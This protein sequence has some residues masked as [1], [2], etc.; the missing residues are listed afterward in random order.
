MPL[1]IDYVEFTS[2]R[3]EATQAFFDA[4]FGWSFVDYGS[5]YRDIQQAGL[6]AGLER[7]DLAPPLVVL[8]STDLEA[9]RDRLIATGAELT[10]DI[11]EFPGW[12]RFEFREPGG[13]VMAVWATL[14]GPTEG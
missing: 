4:A 3:L 13:T 7:G 10:R 6:G 5:D 9:D 14:E 11:F 1:H 12:R 2:P 8:K